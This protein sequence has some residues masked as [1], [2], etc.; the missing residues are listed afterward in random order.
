MVG[1]M[2]LLRMFD[3]G[4]AVFCQQVIVE[5]GGGNVQDFVQVVGRVCENE[6]EFPAVQFLAGGEHVRLVNVYI[7]ES[8]LSCRFL[9]E[10][11]MLVV[12]FN[13]N[14]FSGSSGGEFV[15]DAA[16]SG[17]EVQGVNPFYVHV[18]GQYVEQVFFGEIGCRTCAEIL[19]RGNVPASV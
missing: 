11:V 19:V 16:G 8:Q 18:I 13:G 1:E 9:N 15:A 5:N 4:D 7:G 6:V 2:D 17:K 14:D 12:G 3:D 10:S